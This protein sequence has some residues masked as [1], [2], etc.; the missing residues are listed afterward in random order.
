MS[1]FSEELLYTQ[2]MCTLIAL[3]VCRVTALLVH[4]L[5]GQALAANGI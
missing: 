5:Q 3:M 2:M 4:F 1:H